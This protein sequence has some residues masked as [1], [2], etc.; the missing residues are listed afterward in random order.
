MPLVSCVVCVAVI[1][2]MRVGRVAHCARHVQVLVYGRA[3][4][5]FVD[6]RIPPPQP[7]AEPSAAPPTYL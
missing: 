7:S 2:H 6:F 1:H 3:A 4:V 5:G